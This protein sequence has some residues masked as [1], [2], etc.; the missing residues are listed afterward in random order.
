MGSLSAKPTTST[1]LREVRLMISC[2]IRIGQT[3][4]LPAFTPHSIYILRQDM[5]T[6][7]ELDAHGSRNSF[8]KA[9]IYN[10]GLGVT[11]NAATAKTRI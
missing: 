11:A 6:I 8:L 3:K 2:A 7:P 5:N 10:R 4:E 1:P 9:E